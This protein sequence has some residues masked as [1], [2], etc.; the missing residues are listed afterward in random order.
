MSVPAFASVL[1][2]CIASEE[3]GH[4]LPDIVLLMTW[5]VSVTEIREMGS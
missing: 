3:K 2:I 4:L 5:Y 1:D